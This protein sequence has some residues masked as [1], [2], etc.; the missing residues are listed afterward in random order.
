MVLFFGMFTYTKLNIKTCLTFFMNIIYFCFKFDFAKL[1]TFKILNQFL[2][3]KCF[4]VH[5][6]V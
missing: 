6:N 1:T 3:F 2:R 4:D 5:T